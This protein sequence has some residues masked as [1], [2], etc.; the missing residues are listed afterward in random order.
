[1]GVAQSAEAAEAE[2]E[3]H[4]S[5]AGGAGRC[6]QVLGVDVMLSPAAPGEVLPRPSV[7]SET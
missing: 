4:D 6:F 2:A 1:M 3:A 5:A 7:K